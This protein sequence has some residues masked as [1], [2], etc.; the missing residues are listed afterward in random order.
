MKKLHLLILSIILFSCGENKTRK[1]SKEEI[2]KAAYDACAA[3]QSN[4]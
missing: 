2:E 4:D 3:L 1:A